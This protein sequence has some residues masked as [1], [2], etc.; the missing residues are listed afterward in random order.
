VTIHP[1]FA[2]GAILGL[3][4]LFVALIWTLR[5]IIDARTRELQASVTRLTHAQRMAKFGSYEWDRVATKLSLSE[6][7]YRIFGL[8][9]SKFDPSF[10]TFT[11]RVHEDDRV[12]VGQAVERAIAE[13]SFFSLEYR[14]VRPD[15]SDKFVVDY[16]EVVTDGAGEAVLLRGA[17]QDITE[18]KRTEQALSDAQVGLA[19]AYWAAKI[20]YWDWTEGS[21]N[22]P[23]NRDQFMSILG[24]AADH[25]PRTNEEQLRVI[26]PDDRQEVTRLFAQ[27]DEEGADYDIDYRILRADGEVRYVREIGEAKHDDTGRFIGH[28]GTV[29]DISDLKLAETELRKS[30]EQFRA[31]IEN[32]SD[33][34]TIIDPDGTIRFNSPTITAVL[35]YAPDELVGRNALE[36][37]HPDD[38]SLVGDTLR[39]LAKTPGSM[40]AAEFRFR[41]K[42]GSWRFLDSIG[43]NALQVPGVEG[44]VVNSRDITDNKMMEDQLHQAQKMEAVGQLT[45]GIAHDFNNL[46]AVIMGNLELLEGR[47]EEDSKLHLYAQRAGAAAT[48]GAALTQRLL[49]FSR[50]QP[51]QPEV[52][53]LGALLSGMTDLMGR[54]LGKAIEVETVIAPDLWP[55]EVDPGQMENALLNLA[56]NARDAMPGGGRLTIEAGNLRIDDDTAMAGA[57]RIKSG[58]Y[59]VAAVTDNGTGMSREVMERVFDPFFTTKEVGLGSGLG[60][61]M[62]YGFA[63]QSDGYVEVHSEEGRGTAVKIYLPRAK[64]AAAEPEPEPAGGEY[65]SARGETI[66]VV[67]D[68]SDVRALV[69]TV[70]AELGYRVMEAHAGKAALTLLER[71]PDIDLLVTDLALPEGMSGHDLAQVVRSRI[72]GIGVLYMSGYAENAIPDQDR[73]RRDFNL[74]HKPFR[75]QDLAREVRGVLDRGAT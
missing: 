6:E 62:V 39:G 35:G 27:A 11:S 31:L 16:G 3:A 56:I 73:R 57:D 1:Y 5:R 29:Q 9:P 51:L 41:H 71:S 28:T 21:E 23:Y 32:A 44:L 69:V 49:A 7:T 68:D 30:E 34:I 38:A 64:R 4:A 37:V 72:P 52:L 13:K 47:L 18:R 60:L 53:D 58:D 59:V 54:T 10:D 67:E 55:C 43:K 14:I 25:P 8:E 70:L 2:A 75:K 33:I 46:L 22:S 74:L 12:R 40:A 66:L 48:R 17:V 36:L 15:G 63:K 42:D 20:S 65:P 19:R 61:S 26:H 45:G 24:K 50:R